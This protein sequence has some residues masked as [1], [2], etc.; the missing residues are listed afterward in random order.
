MTP[1]LREHRLEGGHHLIRDA[2][3]HETQ[4][5]ED[6]CQHE[7][8]CNN[9]LGLRR[10]DVHLKG[11][12]WLEQCAYAGSLPDCG[13]KP[14]MGFRG[15]T[16]E[17][18]RGFLGVIVLV[19][20][21]KF[22]VLFIGLRSRMVAA[23]IPWGFTLSAGQEG[24][25]Y[26]HVTPRKPLRNLIHPRAMDRGAMEDKAG[27][28]LQPL[29]DCLA[30]MRCDVVADH[31]DRRDRRGNLRLKG[32][33]ECDTLTLAFAAMTLPIDPACAGSKGREQSP[34]APKGM[35]DAVWESRLRWLRGME[36]R[37]W[38]Q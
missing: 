24:R 17:K 16:Y 19:H 4:G 10:S 3:D 20:P 32:G 33:Q 2:P 13:Q 7:Q 15:E 25:H 5:R 38:L 36:P 22:L 26:R 18:N 11:G 9:L 6:A 8:L 27:M 35:F 28:A 21:R 14:L 23:I 12:D 1:H 37:L 30:M 34:L 31:V 29:A